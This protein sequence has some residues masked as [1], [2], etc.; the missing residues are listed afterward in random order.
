MHR[1]L[2]L[3]GGGG[4]LGRLLLRLACLGGLIAL[5]VVYREPIA[6]ALRRLAGLTPVA[7]LSLPLFWLWNHVASVGW[8]GLLHV[9]HDGDHV[10]GSARLTVVRIE[11]QALNVVLPLASI[12]G[13]VLRSSLVARGRAR[14]ASSASAVVLDTTAATIAGLLFTVGGVALRFG[15]LPLR[16]GAQLA[17]LLGTLAV[18][19][20]LFQVPRVLGRLARW[21]RLAPGSAV[22]RALRVFALPR[23]AFA[24]ALRWAVLCH[25]VERVL[26]AGEVYILAHALGLRIGPVDALFAAAVM[27][28]FTLFMFFIPAQA[29]AAEG[30]MAL[31][32]ATLGLGSPAGLAVALARRGRQLITTAAGLTLLLV[33]E[34]RPP[35]AL[36][37]ERPGEPA[38]PPRVKPLPGPD[39]A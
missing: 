1:P 17:V 15:S 26:T 32:F 8:R 10:P 7:L 9:A 22:R 36:A 37:A 39:V 24:P 31:A 25:L 16:L 33:L 34:G 14:L 3:A 20:A 35:R 18:A 27:T 28:G 38:L 13:D 6:V 29:G 21:R 30:G 12:G 23:A 2:R 4:R 19:V 11:A 5:G